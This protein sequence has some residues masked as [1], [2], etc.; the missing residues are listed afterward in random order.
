[1]RTAT[2]LLDPLGVALAIA[3][4]LAIVVLQEGPVIAVA[5]ALSVLAVRMVA[6]VL[7]VRGLRPSDAAAKRLPGEWYAPLSA[8]EAEVALLVAEGLHDKEIAAR[9]DRSERT[10]ESHVLNINTKLTA[11]TKVPYRNRAQIAV[12]I[13]AQR[14]RAA[15]DAPSG[16]NSVPK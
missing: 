5:A 6:G 3:T 2:G 14:G 8:K 9:L 16:P 7:A 15:R 12:W 11:Y 4:G 13:T 10:V 1:M